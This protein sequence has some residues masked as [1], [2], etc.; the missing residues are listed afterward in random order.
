MFEVD[1]MHQLET[2]LT[3]L[4]SINAISLP[5]IRKNIDALEAFTLKA[6]KSKVNED[7]KKS[8]AKISGMKKNYEDL[9][10]KIDALNAKLGHVR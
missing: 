9:Q 8:Q 7:N 6:L 1:D 2:H 3:H 5:R 4:D 10:R